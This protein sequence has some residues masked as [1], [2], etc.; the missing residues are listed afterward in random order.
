MGITQ[1]MN[2]SWPEQRWKNSHQHSNV[3]PQSSITPQSNHSPLANVFP[4]LRQYTCAKKMHSHLAPPEQNT[5][6]TGG[7]RSIKP[8][9]EMSKPFH[10][11]D[12]CGSAT[13]AGI[14]TFNE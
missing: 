6:V 2:V 1:G 9:L 11:V 12:N 13:S 3:L 10:Y 8:K 5:I 4:Y 7:T 14:H